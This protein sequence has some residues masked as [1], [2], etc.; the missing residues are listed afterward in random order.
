MRIYPL[1]VASSEAAAYHADIHLK[2]SLQAAQ[3][4]L[5]D[6]IYLA[7][8]KDKVPVKQ[9][10]Q[11]ERQYWWHGVRILPPTA[12]LSPWSQWIV[13]NQFNGWWMVDY[14]FRLNSEFKFRFDVKADNPEYLDMQRWVA[15]GEIMKL[16]PK[17]SIGVAKT[18][19]NPFPLVMPKF[20]LATQIDRDKIEPS[21]VYRTFYESIRG[22][23]RMRWSKRSLPHFMEPKDIPF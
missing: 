2:P 11:G 19:L 15:E 18:V 22:K 5:S 23:V 8:G 10:E 9:P 4:F 20:W 3:K 1:A 16:F 12:L 21:L 14:A 6:A 13:K 17:P 7:V